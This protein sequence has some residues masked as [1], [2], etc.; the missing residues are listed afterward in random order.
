MPPY[1]ENPDYY[2]EP[3]AAARYGDYYEP[4][5]E[6]PEPPTPWYRRPLA[7]VAAGAIGVIL[8][9]LLAYAVFK[10]A[11]GWSAPSPTTE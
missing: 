10:L 5:P 11:T 4:A 9:A 7:L 2:S 1:P 8:L 3:T 6:P